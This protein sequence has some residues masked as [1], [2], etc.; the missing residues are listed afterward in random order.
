MWTA[1]SAAVS[2]TALAMLSM[3]CLA[4]IYLMGKARGT[5]KFKVKLFGL[6]LE[7]EH[8]QQTLEMEQENKPNMLAPPLV[9]GESSAA[10]EKDTDDPPS[11]ARTQM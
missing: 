11:Q 9:A 3:L 8:Q 1:A 6:G 2:L 10:I 4:S 7:I 5:W